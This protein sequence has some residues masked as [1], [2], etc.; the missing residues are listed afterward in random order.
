MSN[1]RGP[2]VTDDM[3]RHAASLARRRE[4]KYLFPDGAVITLQ[5]VAAPLIYSLQ[6]DA[7]K[8]VAPLRQVQ[9]AGG[10]TK[11][12]DKDDPDYKQAV[13]EWELGKAVQFARTMI[14]EG[15]KDW[16]DD[17][18]ILYWNSVGFSDPVE[19]KYRWIASKLFNETLE[20]DF[21]EAIMGLSTPT[22]DGI[23]DAEERFPGDG[24]DAGAVEAGGTV[25]STP[26]EEGTGGSPVRDEQPGGAAAGGAV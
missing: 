8:P 10:T 18:A 26:T 15:V 22:E 4:A 21:Y 16:P 25:E 11:I 9:I 14:L 19:V 7:G 12:Q 1:G 5:A 24:P 23:A 13:A 2:K 17:G 6:S 20:N 3:V